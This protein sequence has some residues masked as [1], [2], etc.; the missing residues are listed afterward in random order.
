[1][2][3]LDLTYPSALSPVSP[4][5]ESDGMK[6]DG[7]SDAPSMAS[8]HEK[9][10]E[11][12][13]RS[14]VSPAQL[15]QLEQFF[16]EDRSPTASRRKEISQALGMPE[17]QTQIWFQNR[18]AKAKQQDG[19]P[20][21]PKPTENEAPGALS[22]APDSN[23]YNAAH[24][25]MPVTCIPCKSLTIGTWRRITIAGGRPDLIAYVC[26]SSQCLTWFIQSEG[27]SF[28][29][30]IPLRN[31]IQTNFVNE[32]PGFGT[33]SF[34]LSESPHFYLKENG[35][36]RQYGWKRCD[37]WTE[38]CQASKILQ[39]DLSGETLQL[40]RLQQYIIQTK[41]PAF[42]DPL[43]KPIYQHMPSTVNT[44]LSRGNHQDDRIPL[45]ECGSAAQFV[46][47]SYG[48]GVM[49]QRPSH[50]HHPTQLYHYQATPDFLQTNYVAQDA[51]VPRYQAGHTYSVSDR[52]PE[53]QFDG[54]RFDA[55][56]GNHF[57]MGPDRHNERYARSL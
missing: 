55:R 57:I 9:A 28:K 47:G 25:E 23:F 29:M 2:P 53:M 46:A 16:A 31:V 19:K 38:D 33:L 4:V 17:R 26:E 49:S 27:W 50:L 10:K 40:I 7:L 18:R 3:E 12:K 34:H 52:R 20:P 15:A 39:H 37:D 44:G 36:E 32:K 51:M 54:M 22:S 24:D 43:Q 11:K 41:S 30:T 6:R 8:L 42:D 14:R 48:A 1:M 35:Q 21:K 5:E 56:S 45:V 13:K